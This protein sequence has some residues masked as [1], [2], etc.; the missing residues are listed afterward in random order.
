MRID[1]LDWD[2]GRV[3]VG[4]KTGRTVWLPRPRSSSGGPG[5]R[6]AA[7]RPAS[8]HRRRRRRHNVVGQ[9]QRQARAG[10]KERASGVDAGPNTRYRPRPGRVSATN[11]RRRSS[12][13]TAWIA[14]S[15]FGHPPQTL[16]GHLSFDNKAIFQKAYLAHLDKTVRKGTTPDAN[17]RKAAGDAALKQTPFY[18][19]RAKR[20]YDVELED[21]TTWE[22]IVYGDPP[23]LR[24]VPESIDVK[25]K[26][27]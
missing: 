14:W 25:A 27:R 15:R 3:R 10:D 12:A 20:R 5:D 8:R 2:H 11:R 7:A 24:E 6:Q 22:K 17:Q 9:R 26:K 21:F 4:G 1:D 23:E 19:A 13:E 16:P 18:E